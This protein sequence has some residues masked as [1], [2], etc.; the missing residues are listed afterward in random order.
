MKRK[1]PFAPV[2]H[3]L[4]CAEWAISYIEGMR[5][6]DFLD[7]KRT[8]QAVIMNLLIIGEMASRLAR[9]HPEFWEKYPQ[10]PWRQMTSMRNRIAHGYFDLC[11][12]TIWNTASTS[13]P[14]LVCIVKPIFDELAASRSDDRK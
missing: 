4:E 1:S 10:A 14:E 13:L 7:D 6:E 3:M 11:L 12:D 8:Q 2:G 5:K 9:D